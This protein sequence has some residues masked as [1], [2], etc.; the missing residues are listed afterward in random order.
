[1]SKPVKT[2]GFRP[3]GQTLAM[4]EKAEQKGINVADLVCQVLDEHLA[5][6]YETAVRERNK[7]LKKM[8]EVAA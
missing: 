2:R 4:I 6:Y 8:L 5:P 7:E 3:K 1:M